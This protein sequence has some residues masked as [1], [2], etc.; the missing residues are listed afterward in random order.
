MTYKFPLRV[1]TAFVTVLVGRSWRHGDLMVSALNSR[2]NGQGL[3][4]SVLTVHLFTQA[5]KWIPENLMLGVTKRWTSFPSR[6]DSPSL[7]HATEVRII[8]QPWCRLSWEIHFF[9]FLGVIS[10]AY[11]FGKCDFWILRLQYTFRSTIFFKFSTF[12]LK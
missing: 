9:F 3:N 5:Y 4:P 1:S 2:S 12:P 6:R 11:Q 7:L 10:N 8:L